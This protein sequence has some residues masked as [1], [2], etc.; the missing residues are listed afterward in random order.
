MKFKLIILGLIFSV[1][2]FASD[3]IQY[4]NNGVS[5]GMGRSKISFLSPITYRTFTIETISQKTKVFPNKENIFF[6][7][8]ELGLHNNI[9]QN[10]MFHIGDNIFWGQYHKISYVQNPVFKFYAGYA[11]LNNTNLYLKPDNINNLLYTN[12]N[13]M[14]ALVLV[15]SK[16]FKNVYLKN[17]FSIPV[18]GLYY[19][20]TFSQNL[21]GIVEKESSI[22][23]ASKLGSFNINT[24]ICNDL[25]CD[26]RIK[27]KN[28]G[29]QTLRVQYGFEYA[30]LQLH[31]NIKE[32]IMHQIT[33]S[34]LIKKTNYNHAPTL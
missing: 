26:F 22:W 28:K 2:S 18:Y 16:Q 21:P 6:Y 15:G 24:Q 31:N 17:T 19:G 34:T 14:A 5:F 4:S 1:H 12:F 32:T 29:H 11:Y 30:K 9:N 3:T 27:Y 13:N 23:S 33:I 7:K 25:I 10:T 8:I 20:S